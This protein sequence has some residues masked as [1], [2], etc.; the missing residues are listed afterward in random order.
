M[1]NDKE[2]EVED[3]IEDVFNYKEA[4]ERLMRTAMEVSQENIRLRKK[5]SED[6]EGIKE[7]L[8]ANNDEMFWMRRAVCI[9]FKDITQYLFM[10]V[11]AILIMSMVMVK[12]WQ[13][14]KNKV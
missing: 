10:I 1:E 2:K 6:I 7:S 14:V 9:R 11:L 13:H 12:I 4:N 5:L 3:A 8:A